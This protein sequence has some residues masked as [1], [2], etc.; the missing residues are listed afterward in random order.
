MYLGLIPTKIL[1]F[2]IRTTFSGFLKAISSLCTA[3]FNLC[4]LIWQVLHLSK[5]KWFTFQ[6]DQNC[7]CGQWVP[8]FFTHLF[9]YDQLRC[10]SD[11]CIRKLVLADSGRWETTCIDSQVNTQTHLHL[12]RERKT[13]CICT[14]FQRQYILMNKKNLEMW[15]AFVL[16]LNC[17]L[18]I[19]Q[20]LKRRLELSLVL[21]RS[22]YNS[23][24]RAR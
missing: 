15:I 3:W 16:L 23:C 22:K 18:W 4:G 24:I 9:I 14:W 8:L 13:S 6:T 20:R 10:L 19:T 12:T 11:T 1:L 17:K 7:W 2:F 5:Y 21:S